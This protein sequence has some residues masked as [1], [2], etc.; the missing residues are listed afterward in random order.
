EVLRDRGKLETVP[1]CQLGPGEIFYLRAGQRS[2][3]DAR[4][5]VHTKG[6]AVDL[7]QLTGEPGDVRTCTAEANAIHASDSGNVVLKDS[8]LLRGELFCMAVRS[9][10]NALV[11]SCSSKGDGDRD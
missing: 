3:V 10:F 9:R 4:I 11:P 2:P 1:E 6:A 5:L 7:Q 8:V